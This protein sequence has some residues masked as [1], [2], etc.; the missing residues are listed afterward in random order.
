HCAH[1]K[2]PL[3]NF[4]IPVGFWEKEHRPGQTTGEQI[5]YFNRIDPIIKRAI[6][7]HP[8]AKIEFEKEM[9]R[10]KQEDRETLQTIQ[11][12][13]DKIYDDVPAFKIGSYAINVDSGHTWQIETE[14]DLLTII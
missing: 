10:Q 5:Q 11:K 13:L 3:I 6:H 2:K 8:C 14:N 9:A 7:M 4:P 1:C 12:A